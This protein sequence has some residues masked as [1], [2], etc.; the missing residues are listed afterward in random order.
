MDVLRASD[1]HQLMAWLRALYVAGDHDGFVAHLVGSLPALVGADIVAYNEVDT[2]RRTVH[3]VS[4]PQ[5]SD[6]LQRAFERRMHEHPLLTHYRHT[7]DG[8]AVKFSDF[9]SR[10]QYHRLALYNECYRFLDVEYQMSLIPCAAPPVVIGIALNRRVG[11]FSERDR[12][13]LNLLQPHVQQA[14]ANAEVFSAVQ[15]ELASLREAVEASG[16]GVA[17]LVHTRGCDRIQWCSA[18]PSVAIDILRASPPCG[19]AARRVGAL[20]RS[21]AVTARRRRRKASAPT[22]DRGASRQAPERA[23]GSDGGAPVP[24]V[25]GTR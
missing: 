14:F 25:R 24:P 9:L 2:R 17:L 3:V 11:D 7:G 5:P 12:L 19:G 23:L 22:L 10:P 20:G 4:D 18:R 13:L 21:P 8:S 1:L 16:Q 6:D 15:H